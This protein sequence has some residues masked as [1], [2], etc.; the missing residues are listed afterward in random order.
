MSTLKALAML[1]KA[2]QNA[3]SP[4]GLSTLLVNALGE[5]VKT[6]AI[7]IQTNSRTA[8]DLNDVRDWRIMVIDSLSG[9]VNGAPV[10]A[11]GMVLI[12]FGN[13][14][15][16]LRAGEGGKI[17]FRAYTESTGWQPWRTVSMAIL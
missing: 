16:I 17:Y 6:G 10:R 1:L 3:S 5:L 11:S 7:M 8:F 4:S 13:Y 12:S 15:I 2:V 14:H 9:T